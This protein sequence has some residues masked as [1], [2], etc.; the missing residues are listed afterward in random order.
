M[1]MKKPAKCKTPVR[2]AMAYKLTAADISNLTKL[3]KEANA[4]LTYYAL[5]PENKTGELYAADGARFDLLCEVVEDLKVS[6]GDIN[7]IDM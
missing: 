3:V 4:I 6:I 5:M 2:D 1:T 7:L